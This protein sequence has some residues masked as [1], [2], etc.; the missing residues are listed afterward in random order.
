MN[1]IYRDFDQ[2]E[3]DIQYNAQATVGDI[4]PILL[5]YRRLSDE[6]KSTLA[7]HTDLSFGPDKEET[8]DLFPAGDGAPLFVFIHGGYWRL[9][10]KDDSSFMAPNL[11]S[12]G[13]AVAAVNYSLRPHATLEEI[14]AEIRRSIAW[15]YRNAGAYGIDCERIFIGGSSAGGH[16]AGMVVSGGWHDDYGVPPT[17]VKGGLLLSGLYDLLPVSLSYANEWVGLDRDSAEKSSPIKAIPEKGCPLVLSYGGSETSEFKRQSEDFAATWRA[18]GFQADCF[19][20]TERNHFDIPL[21]LCD[22]D[23]PVTG[24]LIDLLNLDS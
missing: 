9:L 1:N 8:L 7:C 4:S 13:I 6:A 10:S 12:Q 18:T 16:L 5:E 2:A 19:E 21:D 11:V 24:K 17:V 22:N 14:V 23:N 15:L 3:L 20:R